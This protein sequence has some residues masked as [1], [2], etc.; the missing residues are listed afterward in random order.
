MPEGLDQAEVDAFRD[1]LGPDVDDLVDEAIET[2]DIDD[3]GELERLASLLA[4]GLCDAGPPAEL[5]EALASLLEERGDEAAATL[6]AVIALLVPSFSERSSASLAAL[7][8]AGVTPTLPPGTGELRASKLRRFDVPA[9]V[10]YLLLIRRPGSELAQVGIL[11]IAAGEYGEERPWGP[12]GECTLTPWAELEDAEDLLATPDRSGSA[13]VEV[14]AEEVA[15]AIERALD[16]NRRLKRPVRWRTGLAL[17]LLA[18]ALG[19]D[20]G[21][22]GDVAILA[23]GMELHVDPDDGDEFERM[24]EVVLADFADWLGKFR[25]DDE[26]LVELAPQVAEEM[27]RWG[28]AADGRL[29]YWLDQDIEDFLLEAAPRRLPDPPRLAARLGEC[30]VTFLRFLDDA[31]LL[32]GLNIHELESRCDELCEWAAEAAQDRGRW[33]TAK[34]LVAQMRAEGVELTDQAAL[35]AWLDDFNSRDQAERDR[36]LGPSVDSNLLRAAA[37]P[38]VRLPEELDAAALPAA[39]GAVA[40]GSAWFPPGDYERALKLWPELDELW[41]GIAYAEYVRR[42]EATL[43]GWRGRGIRARPVRLS[44]DAYLHWCDERDVDADDSRAAYATDQM[45]AGNG[46]AWPPGRNDACWCESGRK[47]KR[48]C[49]T[50]TETVLHPLDANAGG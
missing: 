12:I 5:G 11:A 39:G 25:A 44:I 50:V 35:D 14:S 38:D 43:R 40:V 2:G 15:T 7:A 9:G 20:G 23:E 26:E 33:G 37:G 32:A 13:G 27:L 3:P 41:E 18:L 6:L 49:G 4:A 34:T 36:V 30:G 45:R 16:Q 28:W 21:G 22:F 42:F 48:C 17:P 24:A 46:L 1:A 31:E 47:Y 29:A 19:R 10:M 8:R